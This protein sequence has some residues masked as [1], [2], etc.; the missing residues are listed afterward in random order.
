V[1]APPQ[2]QPQPAARSQPAVEA[3]GEGLPL[4][5]DVVK[6]I[7]E[8]LLATRGNP[9]RI[10]I[11]SLGTK[12]YF[13]CRMKDYESP[14][15]ILDYFAQGLLDSIVWGDLT[16]SKLY[17]DLQFVVNSPRNEPA[18]T[19]DEMVQCLQRR[20]KMVRVA[21][22]SQPS[23][24]LPT[25]VGNGSVTPV[26]SPLLPPLESKPKRGRT[27]GKVS[28]LRLKSWSKKRLRSDSQHSGDESPSSKIAKKSHD[29]E[30]EGDAMDE[31]EGAS[32]AEGEDEEEGDGVSLKDDEEDVKIV[33]RAEN[34]P[35]MVPTGPNGTWVC[36]QEECGYI[37]R[38]ADEE[39]CKDRI[40]E[41]FTSHQ[42]QSEQITLAMKEGMGRHLPIRY[43]SFPG[44]NHSFSL[45]E[46]TTLRPFRA[47]IA[48]SHLLDKIRSLG[49]KKAAPGQVE[50]NGVIL[51]QPIKRRLLI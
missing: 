34:I 37:V 2:P 51:T 18:L 28:A 16:G 21:Q 33:V 5:I 23:A 49:E 6:E 17:G 10:S 14:G 25:Q 4:L 1:P 48:S 40:R 22:S 3:S 38:A 29:L 20:K 24:G 45:D 43:V 7:L 50:L 13:K 12:L 41:H 27:A 36:D 30:E 35:T 39:D 9:N 44:S 19:M 15:Q 46:S 26:H 42:Q 32:S 47:K 8:D 11:K 31:A